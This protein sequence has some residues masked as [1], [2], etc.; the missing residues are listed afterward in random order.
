VII[1][2]PAPVIVAVFPLTVATAALPLAKL[3]DPEEVEVGGV[4][5]R[6][7]LPY[8]FVGIMNVPSFGSAG[9]TVRVAFVLAER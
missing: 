1:V 9:V 5:A 8:F 2:L 7:L 6:G 4:R 3:H